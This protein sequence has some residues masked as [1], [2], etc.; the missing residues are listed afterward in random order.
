MEVG[1]HIDITECP[2]ISDVRISSNKL[3]NI[4]FSKTPKLWKLN[5]DC[6]NL[7]ELDLSNN[8][9][10]ISVTVHNQNYN[11]NEKHL[12]EKLNV[13]G[14][15]K[16]QT[17]EIWYNYLETLDL[18]TNTALTTLKCWGNNLKILDVSNCPAL[19][20][21]DCSPMNTLETV[22]VDATQKINYIT[23]NRSNDYIPA[24][25]S[26]VVR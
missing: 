12:L 20:L 16:L 2:N 8:P 17:L 3:T 22:Y 13:S 1:S 9:E 15:S 24:A 6:P 7:V 5:M 23:Y 19:T 26:V 25:T 10:L 21:L 14:C 4:D 18:S 11:S